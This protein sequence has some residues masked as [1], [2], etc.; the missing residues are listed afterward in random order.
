M[1]IKK[2]VLGKPIRYRN[3]HGDVW[4]A[5][6]GDDGKVYVFS[7]DTHGFDNSIS[8]NLA[9]HRLTGKMPPGL[10][11]ETINPMRQFGHLAEFKPEDECMWKACGLT[12]VDGVLY[13]SVSRH[14]HPFR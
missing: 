8:S 11:A 6:W 3:S 14:S 1:M 5:A 10:R 9:V 12:C 2:L 13:M 7:D 4:T